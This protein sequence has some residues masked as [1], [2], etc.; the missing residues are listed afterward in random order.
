MPLSRDENGGGTELNGTKSVMYCS[1]CYTEGK[2]TL[3]NIKVDEMK[4]RV[5]GKLS[6]FGVPKFLQ[7]FFTKN[8]HKLERWK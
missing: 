8:I 1:H 4:N 6:E 7:G 5:K 3:P 2:F